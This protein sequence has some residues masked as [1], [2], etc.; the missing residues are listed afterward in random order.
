MAAAATT[1]DAS[2][3]RVESAPSPGTPRPIT[4]EVRKRVGLPKSATRY[5]WARALILTGVFGLPLALAGWGS[6]TAILALVALIV[7][8]AWRAVERRETTARERLY[9]HGDEAVARIVEI[10]PAGAGRRDHVVHVEYY[11][12]NTRHDARIVAAPLARKGLRP[13]DDAAIVF[14][15]KEPTRCL[16]ILKIARVRAAEPPSAKEAGA[17]PKTDGAPT[18]EIFDAVFDEEPTPMGGGG[19]GHGCGCR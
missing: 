4:A 5:P 11:V 15:P 7:L 17:E 19:C 16:L 1:E 13:G 14:D 10:E 9:T 8:P 3:A 12:G 2:E 18:A 6:L